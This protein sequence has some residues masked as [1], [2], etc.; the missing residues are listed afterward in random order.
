MGARA[1]ATLNP[2][3]PLPANGR[4]GRGRGLG[5]AAW[6]GAAVLASALATVLALAAADRLWPP[7]TGEGLEYSVQVLAE[8]GT[9]LRLYTTSDGYWRLPVSLE[10]IDPRFIERLIGVEDQRFYRHHGVDPLALARAL[11]QALREGRVVSGGSTLTMQTVRLLEP[12]PR[13]LS[14]KAIELLRAWQ[15]E[16]RLGKDEILELYLTLA[17]YGGNLQG[18]AA[19]SRFWFGREPRFLTLE[20]TALLVVLPQAPEA[21]RP[22]RRPDRAAAARDRMLERWAAAG[23]IDPAALRTALQAPVPAARRP[24]PAHAAH[25]ADRLRTTADERGRVRTSIDA[26]LQQ[27]LERLLAREQ[28]QFAP[29][30][31]SAALIVEHRTGKVRAW[32]G[33]GD[34]F[35]ESFPGQV[36]M[37]G[38]LRSP[39]S[40]LKPFIY[41]L[42]F[43]AG[44]AHPNTL[45]ADRADSRR[46]YNPRNFDQR[47]RGEMTLAEALAQ[48]RNVPAVR[49]LERV[50]VERLRTLLEA[51]GVPVR[52]PGQGR[53]GLAIGLGGM[54]LNMLDIAALYGAIG[55]S[56]FSARPTA[57]PA[58]AGS[59]PVRLLSPAAAW[60]VAAIL[61]ETPRPDGRWPTARPI[62]VKT[63]TSF[64]YR[65]AWAAGVD[66]RHTVVTWAGRPDGGYTPGFTGLAVAVPLLLDAFA[67]LPESSDPWPGRAPEGTLLAGNEALPAAW[68]RLDG[69]QAVATSDPGGPRVAFPADGTTLAWEPRRPELLLDVRGGEPPLTWL[70]DGRPVTLPVRGRHHL[71][72]PEQPGR[73]RLTVID[74]RGRAQSTRVELLAEAYAASAAARGSTSSAPVEPH[75]RAPAAAV[76]NGGTAQTR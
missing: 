49:V 38:A 42:A 27:R 76:L 36:D 8:D 13:R 7:P 22:D 69:R 73:Y 34:Y 63:G 65:D 14:S 48:S 18:V 21:R 59:E 9:L 26:G 60:Q 40:L 54:G 12:R 4:R 29:G 70:V 50:G 62:A 64:G 17:P 47:H 5:V 58:A 1:G 28:R 37:V 23:V 31:T 30:Q 55:E 15:L 66:G 41:G 16:R 25:L 10:D 43:D 71:W 68:R 51:A 33:S 35:G 61:A 72:H 45:V 75:A 52:V 3:V 2:P 44:I 20:E 67:L 24:A 11:L 32:A 46:A 19:A 53:P 6:A 39:G 57:T 56:G 74:A